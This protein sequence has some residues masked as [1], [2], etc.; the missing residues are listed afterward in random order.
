MTPIRP[1]NPELAVQPP[2]P[3]PLPIVFEDADVLVVNKPPGLLIHRSALDAHEPDTLMERL[4]HQ[5]G[6]APTDFLAPAHRLDKGTSGLLLLA[7]HPQAARTLG[8]ALSAGH[9]HK[10][11]LALVRGWPAAQLQ[12]EH[13]LARDPELPSTGQP[14]LPALTH[15][16]RLARVEWPF[17]VDGRH[18]SSRYALLEAQPVTGRRHQI[19]RHLKHL[20][21]PLIGDATHG[22]GPHNRAV[23]AWLGQQRLWLHAQHLELTHPG[24]GQP[25]HLYAAPGAEW[26]QLRAHGPWLEDA[27]C[28][29]PNASTSTSAC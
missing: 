23:A 7:R 14:Q 27:A 16:R 13:P 3:A 25:L 19:R 21:H 22:K 29:S 20:A 1:I 9:I 26:A 2:P 10:R 8:A 28:A 15:F 17:A 6:L 4:R 24:T 5:L 18:P 11:Y 12:C